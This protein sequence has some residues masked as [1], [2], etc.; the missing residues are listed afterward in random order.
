MPEHSQIKNEIKQNY[1]EIFQNTLDV[2]YVKKNLATYDDYDNINYISPKLVP[3]F[4]DIF[5]QFY[6][7]K[8]YL[9]LKLYVMVGE[10]ESN[11]FRRQITLYHDIFYLKKKSKLKEDIL[12][13]VNKVNLDKILSLSPNKTKTLR[14]LK[15]NNLPK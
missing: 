11:D 15:L 6:I 3:V 4:S 10:T 8:T 2:T 7:R 1:I 12:R 9:R 13:I 5:I 14:K